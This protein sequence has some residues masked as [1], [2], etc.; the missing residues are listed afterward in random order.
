MPRSRAKSGNLLPSPRIITNAL[1]IDRPF[2]H[3]K[4]THMVMQFGQFL[5]HELTHSPVERGKIIKIKQNFIT[6]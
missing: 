5:D 2:E 6:F 4:Y 3:I 1:H